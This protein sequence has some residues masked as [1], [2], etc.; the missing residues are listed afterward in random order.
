VQSL[1]ERHGVPLPL[2]VAA[3]ERDRDVQRDA[4]HPGRER[5]LRVV[6]GERPPQLRGDLLCQLGA[7]V[8]MARIGIG[9]LEHDLTVAL[10]ELA[11]RGACI[12][13]HGGRVFHLQASW[14]ERLCSSKP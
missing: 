1:V 9:D 3:H 5:A 8:G 7:I 2:A 13:D 4:V 14:C 12:G 11:E 10:E 6:A